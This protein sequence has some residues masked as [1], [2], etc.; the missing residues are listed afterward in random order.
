MDYQIVRAGK[1]RSFADDHPLIAGA[2]NGGDMLVVVGADA[3][4]AVSRLKEASAKPAV[5][6]E[7]GTECLGAYTGEN[8]GEEGSNVLGS[9][10]SGSATRRHRT[11]WS[12]CASR[13][14]RPRRSQPRGRYSS[15]TA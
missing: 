12:S 4:A 14:R 9:R 6:V 5:L 7:L 15:S 2:G 11:W 13:A 1:S 3:G 8:R 10:A